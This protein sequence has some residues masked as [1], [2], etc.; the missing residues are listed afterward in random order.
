M[1]I[2]K[3]CKILGVKPG[4]SAEKVKAAFREKIKTYHPDKGGDIEKA[5]LIL[6][7]YEK[8]KD[9]VP[10]IKVVKTRSYRTKDVNKEIFRDFLN[11]IFVQDPN[12][13]KIINEV[14]QHY[15]IEDDDF[16][17]DVRFSKKNQN[18]QDKALQ[19]FLKIEETFHKIMERFNTQKNR[20]IKYRS[21]ELIKNL[22]S[23]QI[24]Y[25][26]FMVKYPSFTFKC[27]NRLEQIKEI[28]EHAKMAL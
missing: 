12:I 15:G 9:G 3:Y 25:R 17:F 24:L 10:V 26:S 21:L 11:R 27:K 23:V 8:L 2:D 20:P 6:E 14:L 28:M 19:E 22:S 1:E 18:I 5:K 13:L 4:D 16:Y 7:A